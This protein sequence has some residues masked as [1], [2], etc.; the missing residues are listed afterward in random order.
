MT[1]GL[2][3]SGKSTWAKEM[4][5]KDP[6]LVR[7][8][9][10]DLRAMMHS[11]KWSKQNEKQVLYMRNEII[12]QSL[13]GGRSVIVDDTNFNPDHEQKLREFAEF[14]KA[15]FVIKDFT[16]VPLDVCI[17]RD[18]QRSNPV[19]KKVIVGMYRKYI[20][21]NDKKP[22]NPIVYADNLPYCVIFDLDGTLAHITD[23]SPYDGKSCASDVPNKSIIALFDLCFSEWADY[24][25]LSRI[26]LSGR[27][28][29]SRSETEKWLSD[30]GVDY[31]GLFMRAEGDTRKDAIVKKELFEKHIKDKYNVLFIV[32]DRDQVVALWRSMGI[33]CLQC[34]YGDF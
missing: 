29:E 31:D 5:A 25:H 27:N 10:D 18:A 23:R 12:C 7:V 6:N 4:L 15:E 21:A 19:G 26:I 16:N 11:G 9:K 8:N 13:S 3:G 17:A 22:L 24:S 30:H 34:N 20:N 1:K 32:D 14:N 2:P 28:E 33:T